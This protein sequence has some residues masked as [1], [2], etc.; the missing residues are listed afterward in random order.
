M[1]SSHLRYTFPFV[2]NTVNVFFPFFSDPTCALYKL[3]TNLGW[4]QE[5]CALSESTVKTVLASEQLCS[6]FLVSANLFGVMNLVR[7]FDHVSPSS[8]YS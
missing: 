1:C 4:T 6:K 2:V 5:S 7:I 3:I 8:E